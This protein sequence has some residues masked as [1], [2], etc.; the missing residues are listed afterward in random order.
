MHL[1]FHQI[2]IDIWL[3]LALSRSIST[4]KDCLKKIALR[5]EGLRFFENSIYGHHAVLEDFLDDIIELAA[6]FVR[7]TVGTK[8]SE[9]LRLLGI[10]IYQWLFDEMADA[11]CRHELIHSVIAHCG[12]GEAA[13]EEVDAAFKCLTLLVDTKEGAV[14]LAP[15]SGYVRS[16]LNELERFDLDHVR[17][18]FKTVS[19]LAL[20]DG[21]GSDDLKILLRKLLSN[22]EQNRQ[23]LGIVGTIQLVSCLS[24]Y[25]EP[26]NNSSSKKKKCAEEETPKSDVKESIS[27]IDHMLRETCHP[28]TSNMV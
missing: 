19:K 22:S 12:A 2:A 28:Q 15:F 23:A 10:R 16:L 14:S 4:A 9:R 8:Y 21:E 25:Q 26:N 6:S 7:T 20:V 17:S 24:P 5:T 13:K 18:L 1:P 27:M 11:R 3:L